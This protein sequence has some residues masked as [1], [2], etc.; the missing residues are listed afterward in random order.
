MCVMGLSVLCGF[1][2]GVWV[3]MCDCVWM[4]SLWVCGG[5]DILECV[6]FRGC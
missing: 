6:L 5:G 4:Q 1:M 3:M 2:W